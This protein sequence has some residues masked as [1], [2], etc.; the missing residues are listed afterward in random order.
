MPFP[1]LLYNNV[2]MEPRSDHYGFLYA[3]VFFFFFSP[4]PPL[5]VISFRAHTYV[6]LA[7]V[8]V[9]LKASRRFLTV[10]CIT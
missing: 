1:V 2:R 6:Y 8:S 7:R 9:M 3:F 10:A 4:P 5:A